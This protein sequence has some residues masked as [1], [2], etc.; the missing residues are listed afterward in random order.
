VSSWRLAQAVSARGHLGV[1][2]GTALDTVLVRR[3]QDGDPGG[4]M[5][6][7]LAR[8]PLPA[9]AERSLETYWLPGGRSPGRPYRRLPALSHDS[10]ANFGYFRASWTLRVDFIGDLV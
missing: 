1:V 8:F 7:A 9:M 10:P 6:E 3:L 2:S 5:R 4:H